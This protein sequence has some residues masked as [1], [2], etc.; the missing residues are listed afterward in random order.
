MVAIAPRTLVDGAAD[1]IG[2]TLADQRVDGDA[3]V[4]DDDVDTA[5][6]LCVHD[7]GT[8]VVD[9]EALRRSGHR[10]ASRKLGRQCIETV[11][12]S[13]A[14]CRRCPLQD[15]AP[16]PEADDISDHD[17]HSLPRRKR[18]GPFFVSKRGLT[19]LR[20]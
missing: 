20:V 14:Q 12:A 2:P 8:L 9:V 17:G 3:G 11:A 5:E 7:P 19:R 18:S 4:G 1:V 13:C 10:R 6:L 15:G 16:K